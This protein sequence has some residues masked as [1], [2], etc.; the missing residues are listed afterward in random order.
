VVYIYFKFA[1]GLAG[2]AFLPARG[3]HRSFQPKPRQTGSP[4]SSMMEHVAVWDELTGFRPLYTIRPG[5]STA[6]A[7]PVEAVAFRL[8]K[9]AVTAECGAC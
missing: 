7:K 3:N 4:V 6:L 9:Y 1:P 5:R 8:R 2:W